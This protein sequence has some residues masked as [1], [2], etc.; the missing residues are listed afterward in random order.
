MPS[1]R[2]VQILTGVSTTSLSQPVYFP[3]LFCP[4][5]LAVDYVRESQ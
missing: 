5:V 4:A 2:S 1:N 3:R